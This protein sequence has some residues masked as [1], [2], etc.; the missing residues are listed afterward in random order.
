MLDRREFFQRTA[1]ASA[2]FGLPL[3]QAEE[4]FGQETPRLPPRDLYATDSERYWAELRRQWLLAA[5]RINLNCGSVGCTPLPVLRAMIDHLLSS[6]AFRE[7]GYP[8]F[9]YEENPRLR[10]LRDALAAFL[11]CQRDEL[12]LVRNATEG[13][14]VVCNGLDLKP[15][16]EVLLTD[17]EHPGGRCCWEQKAARYGI[18]LNYVA[19]PRPPASTDE[20]L[21]RFRRAFTPRTRVVVFSHITT[22]TG[23][24]LPV[25]E[26]CRS[27]RK[28]G[29]LSHV[30]GAHAIGQIPLNLHDLGCDF[31]V[32]SPHKWLLA[33]KGTGT[34]Y[35]R[36]E[37]LDRLW[38]TIASAEWQNRELKAYRFSNVGTSNLSVMVGLKAALDFFQSVGPERIYQRIHELARQVRDRVQSCPQW[39]LANA[40]HDAFYAGLVSFEPVQGDLKRVLAECAARRIRVAGGAERIRVATHVFTQATELNAL[41]DAFD[42]AVRS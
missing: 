40:S 15:G 3:A 11:H 30:D 39:R 5:D 6:E 34:L 22:V 13:N 42:R 14:N 10:E 38:V 31:Y 21:D 20:L 32:T 23:L 1:V 16:D 9:G 28:Q 36:E 17:Q 8:W 19:L 41:F 26:I 33:P 12:A 2:V 25:K 7:P 37:V 29:I 18:K 24:V 27:A 4:L 35:I